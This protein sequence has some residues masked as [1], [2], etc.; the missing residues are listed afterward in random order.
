[1]SD[2]TLRMQEEVRQ[3]TFSQAIQTIEIGFWQSET[4]KY[5]IYGAIFGFLF[6]TI[7]TLLEALL[8]TGQITWAA[9]MAVQRSDPLLWI[10]DSAPFWLGLFAAIA[11]RRQDHLKTVIRKLMREF[12]DAQRVL[13]ENETEAGEAGS[14]GSLLIICGGTLVIFVLVLLILWL[15]TLIYAS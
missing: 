1:M 5:A 3:K 11:G 10:I 4:F 6:P 14:F 2:N 9:M 13:D 7:A 15:Q 12:P 8:G